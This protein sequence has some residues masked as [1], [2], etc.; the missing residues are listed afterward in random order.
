MALKSEFAASISKI[1]EQQKKLNSKIDGLGRLR[2]PTRQYL[3]QVDSLN[4]ARQKKTA[5]FN[6]KVESLKSKTVGKLKEL[7]LPPQY[8]EPVQQLT[9]KVDDFG[10]NSD[11]IIL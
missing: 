6:S 9:S 8:N 1:D 4:Q 5:E 10:L 7:D 3:G 11:F 2:L